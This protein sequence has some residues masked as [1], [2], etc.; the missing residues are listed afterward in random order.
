M[1]AQVDSCQTHASALLE[2]QPDN[3]DAAI[4]LAE[5]MTHQ[6]RDS[7]EE[8]DRVGMCV[9]GRQGCHGIQHFVTYCSMDELAHAPCILF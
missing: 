3:E 7:K 8:H 5:L 4:M 9:G 2:D 6:V 1:S